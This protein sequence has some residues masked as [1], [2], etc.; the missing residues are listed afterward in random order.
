MIQPMEGCDGHGDGRPSELTIRRYKRFGTSGAGLCWFEATA[1]KEEARANPRQ[2]MLTEENKNDYQ[3]ILTVYEEG[4]QNLYAEEENE[5]FHNPI[6]ILQLTHSGRYSSPGFKN[7]LRMYWYDVLD[8]AYG[9]SREDGKILSDEYLDELPDYFENSVSLAKEIGFDGVDIKSCHRYLLSESFSAFTREDSKYG[10]QSYENRT[11]L[12]K[13][14]MKRV[15]KFASDD[16]IITLR[17]NIFDAIPYPY[18]WGV[19]KEEDTNALLFTNRS[20]VPEPDLTEPI[21]LLNELYDMGI[22]LADLTIANP[23]FNPFVSRPYDI[24]VGNATKPNEHPLEGVSR[25]IA[26]T[27]EVRENVPKDMKLIGT[28]YSWL[29][30]LGGYIAADQINKGNV[31][32]VGWG[33]MAFANPQFAQQLLKEGIID[34]KKTCISCSKCTELMRMHSVAG[35]AIR[36]KD[37]YSPYLKGEKKIDWS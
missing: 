25:F 13:N 36:D 15:Q 5:V 33:R 3:K 7:P 32:M 29:R 4:A 35:C 20:P 11:R 34:K 19:K 16:F 1:V 8:K 30:Y 28:G 14:I 24:P 23:Y 17:L 26:L 6:K 12:L 2:I 18:G 22:R 9:R 21:K 37:V 27:K 10:G 31:D